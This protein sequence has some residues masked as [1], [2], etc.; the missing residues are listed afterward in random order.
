MQERW[1]AKIETGA[2]QPVSGVSC[3]GKMVEV[4]AEIKTQ[5]CR[6]NFHQLSIPIVSKWGVVFSILACE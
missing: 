3:V 5:R 1:T 2:L 6:G 4:I